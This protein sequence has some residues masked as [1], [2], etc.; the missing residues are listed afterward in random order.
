MR[1]LVL[2]STIAGGFYARTQELE[3]AIF[4]AKAKVGD[5]VWKKGFSGKDSAGATMA[6]IT[7]LSV[8][9]ISPVHVEGELKNV[10]FVENK[11]NAGNLYPKLQV[12]VAN[13]ENV[14][15]LSLDLKSDVAQRLIAKLENCKPGDFVKVQAWATPVVKGDRTYINH[16]ASIK[17][18]NG[19][20]IKANPDFSGAIKQQTDSLEST[21]KAA[22]INDVKV[23]NAAKTNKRIEAHKEKLLNMEKKFK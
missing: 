3:K 20:E 21:L 6:A 4:D 19:Q 1:S 22:G 11:D 8:S 13:G 15:L 17:D 18:S 23:I 7:E 16:A 2:Y 5:D 10:S 9:G 12:D 14:M